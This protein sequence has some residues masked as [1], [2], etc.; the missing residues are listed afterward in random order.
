MHSRPKNQGNVGSEPHNSSRTRPTPALPLTSQ[1][2]IGESAPTKMTHTNTCTM[3]SRPGLLYTTPP[4]AA[5]TI[6]TPLTH[7]ATIGAIQTVYAVACKFYQHH[8]RL[9][10][11]RAGKLLWRR[12]RPVGTL[13]PIPLRSQLRAKYS[14]MCRDCNVPLTVLPLSVPAWP[15]LSSQPV[16]GHSLAPGSSVLPASSKPALFPRLDV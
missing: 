2:E 12:R 11:S 5:Q 7:V 3:T 4:E 14:E 15:Q 13:L 16:L 6:E 1:V 9:L 10:C 8:Q